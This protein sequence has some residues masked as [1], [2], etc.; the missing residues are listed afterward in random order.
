VQSLRRPNPTMNEGKTEL[1]K[2]N[3]ML[4]LKRKPG[5]T[6]CIGDDITVTIL[7][8]HGNQVRIGINAP[9]SVIIDRQE[10]TNRK[11]AEKAS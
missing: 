6:I 1:T 4:V 2:E 8:V 9:K 3:D 11:K 7:S 5:E 10:V